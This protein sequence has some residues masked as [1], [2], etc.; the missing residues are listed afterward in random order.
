M[1]QKSKGTALWYQFFAERIPSRYSTEK[2]RKTVN[3]QELKQLKCTKSP[4]DERRNNEQELAKEQQGC[5]LE[6]L[7]SL[8]EARGGQEKEC[9]QV[10][11]KGNEA[12][13]KKEKY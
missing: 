3:E 10:T 4:G 13:W 6:L 1:K 9:V 12:G 8:L 2:E 11:A 5:G 7:R